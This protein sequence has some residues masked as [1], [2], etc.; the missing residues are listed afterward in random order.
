MSEGLLRCC[1]EVTK[2]QVVERTKDESFFS[3][4]VLLTSLFKKLHAG[5]E[6]E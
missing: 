3:E 2:L 5:F 4:L 6:R 1:A